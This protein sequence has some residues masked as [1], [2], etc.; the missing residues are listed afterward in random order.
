[1]ASRSSYRGY[2]HVSQNNFLMVY[3]IAKLND[4]AL[5]GDFLQRLEK[6]YDFD[7][8]GAGPERALPGVQDGGYFDVA[9]R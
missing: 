8:Y 6:M 9:S 5:P 3:K 1:M 7:V 4:V 2:H